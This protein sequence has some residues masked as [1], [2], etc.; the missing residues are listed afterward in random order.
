[1]NHRWVVDL[2]V[3]TAARHVDQGRH[4]EA[5]RVLLDG[6]QLGRDLMQAPTRVNS[7]I[8]AA[9]LA[10]AS[11]QALVEWYRLVDSLPPAALDVLAEGMAVLDSHLV[12]SSVAWAGETVVFARRLEAAG[13]LGTAYAEGGAG[14][15]YGFSDLRLSSD[16]VRRCERWF[17]VLRVLGRR[18]VARTRTRLRPRPRRGVLERVEPALAGVAD[19]RR[20]RVPWRPSRAS[21]WP[22]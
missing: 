6:M 11:N 5:V 13:S 7:M 17:E 15:R 12:P 2:A 19:H 8:G 1:M 21:G 22:E 10:I 4:R 3:V 18:P 9:L 20:T 14:W 16:H